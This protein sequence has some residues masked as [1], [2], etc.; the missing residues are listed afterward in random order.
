MHVTQ[1]DLTFVEGVLDAGIGM[2]IILLS[3]TEPF[4]FVSQVVGL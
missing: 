1:P 3:E 4:E 2:S